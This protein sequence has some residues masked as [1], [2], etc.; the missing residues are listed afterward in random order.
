MKISSEDIVFSQPSIGL[1][2][3]KIIPLP[4]HASSSFS[5]EEMLK[6]CKRVHFGNEQI[7]YHEK[8]KLPKEVKTGNDELSPK[9][10]Q[11][12]IES[13]L[14][15]GELRKTSSLESLSLFSNN[16]RPK[17]PH[18]TIL[19]DCILLFSQNKSSPELQFSPGKKCSRE[20][21]TH[22]ANCINTEI[23]SLGI[24]GVTTDFSIYDPNVQLVMAKL[25]GRRVLA[26]GWEISTKIIISA[27]AYSEV[28]GVIEDL[29]TLE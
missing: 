1:N 2:L 13:H 11:E 15:P 10:L 12:K 23:N 17:G 14:S 21:L 26:R 22:I 7:V 25:S 28:L 9:E 4:S 24:S 8:R 5:K 16:G 6:L 20:R 3:P 27:D 19:T 18:N 29:K